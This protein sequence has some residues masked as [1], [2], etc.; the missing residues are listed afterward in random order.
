MIVQSAGDVECL[1]TSL[2]ISGFFDCRGNRVETDVRRDER[3]SG[4]IPTGRRRQCAEPSRGANGDQ[5]F[6]LML[7]MATAEK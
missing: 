5:F 6:R 4:G 1:A 2:R 7:K 3:R